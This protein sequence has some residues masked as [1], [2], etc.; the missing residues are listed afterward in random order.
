MQGQITKFRDD[1]GF[2]VI[3]TDDG[4]RYRFAGQQVRNATELKIGHE[5]DFVL[6]AS[7]PSDIIIMSGSAWFAFGRIRAGE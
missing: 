3:K 2:G 5:V 1:L 6:H 7:Q 4:R